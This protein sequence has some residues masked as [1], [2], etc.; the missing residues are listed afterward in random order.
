MASFVILE[1]GF[2]LVTSRG[3]IREYK[4]DLAIFALERHEHEYVVLEG[5]PLIAELRIDSQAY[6]DKEPVPWDFLR[7][8]RNVSQVFQWT[9]L[10]RVS[11]HCKQLPRPLRKVAV[12]VGATRRCRTAANRHNPISKS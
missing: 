4:T 2:H 1:D 3:H 6:G 10:R 9:L 11:I 12:A 5:I 7:D 8:A